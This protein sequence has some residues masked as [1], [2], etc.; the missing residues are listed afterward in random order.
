MQSLDLRI[1]IDWQGTEIIPKTT[2]SI[3]V[4]VLKCYQFTKSE[5][6]IVSLQSI[7]VNKYSCVGKIL[8]R[9]HSYDVMPLHALLSI[10]I[11]Q[12]FC[13]RL[14]LEEIYP[15]KYCYCK[16]FTRAG[17]VLGSFPN[18]RGGR[19]DAPSNWA[20]GRRIKKNTKKIG[21]SSKIIWKLL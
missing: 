10:N 6:L 19:L 21:S 13:R 7:C 9:K 5:I 8:M 3:I 14:G 15:D 18:G 16:L 17:P 20:P 1:K 4:S 12:Y 2:Q 11:D